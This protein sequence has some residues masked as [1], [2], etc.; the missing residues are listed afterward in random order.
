[1]SQSP[2]S[3]DLRRGRGASSNPP[4]RFEAYQHE[5]ADDGWSACDPELPPPPTEV[6]DERCRSII[7]RNDSPDI[8]FSQ[9]INPYRGCEHGCIYCYARPTHA[10]LGLSP[11]LDFETK[12]YAKRNAAEALT[13]ELARPGYVCEPIALGANTDPYQPIERRL[14]ITRDILEVLSARNHPVTIVTKSSLVER[15][16]DLLGPM[17]RKNLVQVF[18]S[19]TTL[20]RALARRMEPRA[21]A[22][23]RR[24]ETI[25]R[26]A[27]A[28]I[29]AGVMVAP[30]IPALNDSDIEAILDACHGAGA[31][32]AGYVLLR[33]PHEVKDLFA[34]W[35]DA[36]YPQRAQHVMSLLRASRGG[37]ENDP[38]FHA[39]MR[40][41]G[42]FAD[43]IRARFRNTCR[44][45]GYNL[46]RVELDRSRFTPPA[47]GSPQLSLW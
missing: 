34:D 31:R 39:R 15:D 47:T 40:G 38:R 37:R 44:R 9:S 29:P 1:M 28:G 10:Y 5:P 3:R 19:V 32:T 7:A 24:I 23:Q 4:N 14:R 16:I 6:A 35:L 41:Q 46:L 30:V 33:L 11:G 13:R 43:L 20:D 21:A 2:V 18:V 26:V 8:P 42:V 25:R 22:P 36:H 17:A 12:L 27:E 45:L